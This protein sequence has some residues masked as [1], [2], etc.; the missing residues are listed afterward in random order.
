MYKELAKYYDKIYYRKDYKAESEKIHRL[1]RKYKK[2]NGNEMLDVACGTG[3]HI[4]YFK[5][6]YNITG[7]DLNREMLAIAKKKI[8]RAKLT[9]G[10]M[11]TFRLNKKFD[12]IVCLFSAIGYMLRI[13][14]LQKTINNFKAHL[15]PGGLI[16]IEP[17]ISVNQYK[18]R[19][20]NANYINEPN[21]KL[22]R[23]ARNK[24]VR[25]VLFITFHFLISDRK[26]IR[27]LIDK[28]QLRM[29]SVKEYLGSIRKTGLKAKFIKDGLMSGRGL[30]FGIKK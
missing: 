8:P 11:R 2:T 20:L 7:V 23:I 3:N 1:I 17:F 25:D 13:R 4:Q 22:T 29:Y 16:I 14:D 15:K 6:Y 10:D 9:L 27:Y 18:K 30:Y 24:K 5:K 26:Q 21:L 19:F 12:I 28:H